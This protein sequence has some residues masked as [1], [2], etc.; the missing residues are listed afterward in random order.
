MASLVVMT[1]QSISFQSDLLFIF[2]RLQVELR[3]TSYFLEHRHISQKTV[4][5]CSLVVVLQW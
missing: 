3:T 4:R 5:A 2:L 1:R